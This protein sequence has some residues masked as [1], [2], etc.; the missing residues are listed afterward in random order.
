[1]LIRV[2]LSALVCENSGLHTPST[3]LLLESGQ[4]GPFFG[5]GYREGSR[6]KV[7]LAKLR[8]SFTA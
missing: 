4:R 6:I 7:P 3:A 2:M 8:Q 5:M 1:V